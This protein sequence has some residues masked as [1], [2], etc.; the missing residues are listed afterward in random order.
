MSKLLTDERHVKFAGE[1]EFGQFES[2]CHERKRVA[3]HALLLTI[4]ALFYWFS[5]NSGKLHAGGDVVLRGVSDPAVGHDLGL[6]ESATFEFPG[7]LERNQNFTHQPASSFHRI[8]V[9]FPAVEPVSDDHSRCSLFG[10]LFA[11]SQG[12]EFMC[13]QSGC[14]RQAYG[15]RGAI[16]IR[17]TAADQLDLFT[18]IRSGL[19]R[20]PSSAFARGFDSWKP[21]ISAPPDGSRPRIFCPTSAERSSNQCMMDATDASRGSPRRFF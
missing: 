21:E 6:G 14:V 2:I 13:A 7:Q 4:E 9:A 11:R 5:E 12:Q 3:I 20:K 15:K 18:G 16:R 8:D 19:I 17:Q 1:T 10:R